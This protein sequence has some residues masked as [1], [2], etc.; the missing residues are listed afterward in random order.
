M[1]ERRTRLV[2]KGWRKR[3]LIRPYLCVGRAFQD[4]SQITS[5]S[6]ILPGRAPRAKTELAF[7]KAELTREGER[8]QKM[9][10]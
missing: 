2:R 4:C 9:S 5:T 3:V 1:A 8:Q 7:R 10:Q 6:R